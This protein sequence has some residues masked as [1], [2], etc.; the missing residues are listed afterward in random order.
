MSTGTL[1]PMRMDPLRNPLAVD[2]FNYAKATL[3]LSTTTA[4]TA[5]LA[6]GEYDVESDA[7]CFITVGPQASIT[8][9][10]AGGYPLTAGKRLCV[11][12]RPDHAIAGIVASSTA[13]LT[14]HKVK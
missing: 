9:T 13:T 10:T 4:K 6:E 8:A 1:K 14:L 11:Y 7:D 12:V 3:A 2:L 5:A